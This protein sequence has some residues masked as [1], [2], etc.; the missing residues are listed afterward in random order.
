M[1]SWFTILKIKDNKTII[2][3]RLQLQTKRHSSNPHLINSFI[4]IHHLLFAIITSS[5][6][7]P[8]WLMANILCSLLGHVSPF[9]LCHGRKRRT[10]DKL[11][12]CWVLEEVLIYYYSLEFFSRSNLSSSS[13]V[14]C[15][16][17]FRHFSFAKSQANLCT[18]LMPAD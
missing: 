11:T 6:A 9:V 7:R 3:T 15:K 2:E 17:L 16:A 13:H 8:P 12:R 5:L 10:N 1:N 18:L 14:R 4:Y